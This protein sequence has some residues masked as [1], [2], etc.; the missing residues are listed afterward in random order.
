M[1]CR[2]T[3]PRMSTHYK[4]YV[5]SSKNASD[6]NTISKVKNMQPVYVIDEAVALSKNINGVD[7]YVIDDI[8]GN[9]QPAGITYVGPAP[10]YIPVIEYETR[11]GVV[12]INNYTYTNKLSLVPLNTNYIG[13]IIYYSV[14]AIDEAVNTISHLS[15]VEQVLID[16]K[17]EQNSVRHIYS[18]DD[19]NEGQWVKVNTASWQENIVIG[20]LSDKPSL[21]KFGIPFVETVPQIDA[22]KT[23]F[24]SRPTLC[25]NFGVLEIQNP[26]QRNN[27]TFNFRKLKSYKVQNVIGNNYGQMSEPTYQS[28][29]PLS[30]ERMVILRETNKPMRDIPL[31]EQYDTGIDMFEVIRK[32]GVHYRPSLHRKLGVN[33]YNIPLGETTAVFNESSMQDLIKMQIPAKPGNKYTFTIYLID[34]YGNVSTPTSFG[35]T[36]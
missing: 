36:T 24:D 16:C 17:Y 4:L 11:L 34:V 6:I 29:L 19:L 27:I 26:W 5:Y 18:C 20:N 23:R 32:D 14:I 21:D 15:K 12:K 31:V 28:L 2:I 7:S 3:I 22:D 1:F 8:P 35:V 13:T 10:N 30:I 33:K 25:D 9:S